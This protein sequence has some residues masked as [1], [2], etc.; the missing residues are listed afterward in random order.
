M[1]LN[2]YIKAEEELDSL[3]DT[4]ENA[5]SESE[6]DGILRRIEIIETRISKY[7]EEEPLTRHTEEEY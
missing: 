6:A 3:Y 4:L 2:D 5:Q 7:F 1:T